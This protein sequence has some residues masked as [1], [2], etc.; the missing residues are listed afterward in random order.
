MTPP[1][2]VVTFG[3]TVPGEVCAVLKLLLAAH[4]AKVAV[5]VSE[6]VSLV[7]G[8]RAPALLVDTG[9]ST[10]VLFDANAAVW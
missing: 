3:T 4:V 10:V 7:P 1:R 8:G 5:E 2:I 6:D 9:A